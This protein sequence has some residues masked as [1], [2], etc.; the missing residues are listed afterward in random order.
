ML[1]VGAGVLLVRRQVRLVRPLIDLGLFRLP[2]VGLG[3]TANM[4]SFFVVLGL[5][6]LTGQ[7]LQLV[8]G[9]PPLAAG[10]WSVPSQRRW[11]SV[12]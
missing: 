5:F 8:L 12:T 10:L 11:F 7:Y 4:L 6:L 9:L 2:V 1:G 3:L